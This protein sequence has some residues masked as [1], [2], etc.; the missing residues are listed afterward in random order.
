MEERN[1]REWKMDIDE[2]NMG[3]DETTTRSSSQLS[4]AVAYV[5][6]AKDRKSLSFPKVL[7][8]ETFWHYEG[9]WSN[10]EKRLKLKTYVGKNALVEIARHDQSDGYS[11]NS[12]G[13]LSRLVWV[14]YAP[15]E[16]CVERDILNTEC[17]ADPS[18]YTED[19]F[20]GFPKRAYE[21]T[22]NKSKYYMPYSEYK[23]MKFPTKL[24][25]EVIETFRVLERQEQ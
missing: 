25:R 22:L 5:L 2:T 14:A 20:G 4:L 3:T 6:T 24:E 7:T 1:L 15:T 19:W 11:T 13:N 8:P 17:E 18:Y 23:K 10:K 21:D 16:F 9:E 12:S